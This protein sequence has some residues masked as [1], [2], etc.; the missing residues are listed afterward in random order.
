MVTQLPEITELLR[1]G[2]VANVSTSIGRRS[3]TRHRPIG[4]LRARL[5]PTFPP[6]SHLTRMTPPPDMNPSTTGSDPQIRR[7]I[8]GRVIALEPRRLSSGRATRSRGRCLSGM[9]SPGRAEIAASGAACRDRRSAQRSARA[10]VRCVPVQYTGS[11][12]R[13]SNARAAAHY[14]SV[15][16]RAAFVSYFGSR[17]PRVRISQSRQG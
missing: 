13:A 3:S 14:P 15:Q 10:A 9:C 5:H 6:R 4:C 12:N 1:D 2:L 17:R 8:F 11:R 16:S 7:R